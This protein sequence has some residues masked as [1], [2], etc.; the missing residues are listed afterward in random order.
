[1]CEIS[2]AGIKFSAVK[3]SMKG[4]C[5]GGS[6]IKTKETL[7]VPV[8]WKTDIFTHHAA[9][10]DPDDKIIRCVSTKRNKKERKK[11]KGKAVSSFFFF[12]FFL[13][14]LIEFKSLQ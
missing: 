13:E 1:M 10:R 12:L 3:V 14:E 6:Q 2:H 11:E 8:S 5:P 4:L 9:A 7:N